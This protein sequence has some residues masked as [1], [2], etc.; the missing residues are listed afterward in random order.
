[1]RPTTTQ[2]LAIEAML[3]S[4]LGPR[5]YDRLCLGMKVGGMAEDVLYVFVTNEACAAEI[6]AAHTDDFALAAEHVLNQPVRCVNVVPY[7]FSDLSQ[8]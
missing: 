8:P 5:L 3:N 7:E 4:L 2:Q 6:E 1:M